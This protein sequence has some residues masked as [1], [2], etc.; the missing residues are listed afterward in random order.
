MKKTK[1]KSLMYGCNPSGKA[2][3]LSKLIKA[4][5]GKKDVAGGKYNYP[6]RGV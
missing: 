2:P 6:D 1:L 5:R 4:G 3:K